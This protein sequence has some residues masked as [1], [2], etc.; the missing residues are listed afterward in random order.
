[1]RIGIRIRK[2]YYHHLRQTHRRDDVFAVADDAVGGFLHPRGTE[3]V[4]Q[5]EF[6][7]TVPR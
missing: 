6:T 7:I 1:M 5:S 2:L 4:L 3:H